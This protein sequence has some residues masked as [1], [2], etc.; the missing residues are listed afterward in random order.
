MKTA[1][2]PRRTAK[3]APEDT[4]SHVAAGMKYALD[5]VSG[6]IDACKW[7]KAACQRHLNDL[8]RAETDAFPYQFDSRAGER[9][10]RFIENLPHI[11]G[12]WASRHELI[13][14]QP[15]QC[16]LVSSVFGWRRMKDGTRR[17]REMYLEV[18]RK[19]GKSVFA[20]A[21][22][23]YMLTED[24]E[25][26]AEIYSGATTEAQAWEVFRPARLMA[27]KA[28][29]F[30]E[31]Y[32]VGVN[33]SNLNVLEPASRFEP[34][35]GSPG[36]GASPTCAIIDEYH[37]H[38][39][40]EQYDTM[41]TGMGA[42]TQP[43]I[44]IIT[45]A[46][47]NLSGPCYDK[48]QTQVTKILENV[49]E[50]EEIFA[51]IYTIDDTDDWTDFSVW[52]KANPN[53]GVSVFEDYL[54][55]R[56]REA[57]QMA[58]KQNIIRC[59][60]LNQWMTVDSAWM[61]MVAWRKCADPKLK[62]EQFKGHRCWLALD[63]A[64]KTDFAEMIQLFKIVKEDAEPEYVLFARHYYAE[65]QADYEDNAQYR[66][67]AKEGLITLTEGNIIDFNYIKDDLRDMK[68]LYEIV[69]IPYDPFQATLFATDM[70]AEG[71][72][73]IEYG[74]TVKNFSEPMKELERLVLSGRLRHNGDKVLEW[75][76]SNVIGHLD[77]K[78]NIFPNKDRPENKID[79]AVAAI[80]ALGRA[81]MEQPQSDI[82]GIDVW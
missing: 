44:V 21:I 27:L 69:E 38:R 13:V 30:T 72:P 5:V 26:G 62:P 70:A 54:R 22:G 76:I 64:S 24:G 52:K 60:H 73:M 80:M 61:D 17:F 6:V 59:K 35:I 31:H 63:M 42:R 53:F 68:S 56:H 32:G 37:E 78:D 82:V 50:N 14:L 8:R 12:V 41:A 46:G 48:R 66:G 4:H 51:I 9:A 29:G 11:K 71:F 55:S 74:A 15:W 40:A 16:F 1:P 81:M 77:R 23:L 36:D 28:V 39:T 47:S 20:A 79:G 18:P 49:M 34:V 67:W 3:P 45:T 7:T 58:A 75:M 65:E 43:L 2:A 10:C 33:A 25:A 19:N 57:M